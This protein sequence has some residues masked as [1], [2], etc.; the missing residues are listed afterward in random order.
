MIPKL[1]KS[2]KMISLGIPAIHDRLV[3]EVLRSIL[4][5]IFEAKFSSQSYGFRPGRSCHIALK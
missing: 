5:P 3:Q 4:E 2:G 1:G